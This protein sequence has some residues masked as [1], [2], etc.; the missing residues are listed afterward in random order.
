MRLRARRLQKHAGISNLSIWVLRILFVAVIIAFVWAQNNLVISH[1]IVF[2]DKSIPKSLVGFNLVQVSDISN[3]ALDVADKVKGLNPDAI[4]VTGGYSDADGNY[5][6]SVNTINKLADMAPV[7]YIYSCDDHEDY[8]ANSKGTNITDQ[9]VE[10]HPQQLDVTAF[11]K[12]NYG[13]NIIKKSEK[14]DEDAIKYMEYVSN[15][16]AE[17]SDSKISIYGLDKYDSDNGVYEAEQKN[18]ELLLSDEADYKIALIGNVNLVDKLSQSTVNMLMFGGTY[19]TNRISEKYKS[20]MYAENGTQIVVSSGVGRNGKQFRFMNFPSV[21]CITFSDGT[22][23]QEN[24]LEKFI[25]KFVKDVGTIYDND[26]GFQL[27]TIEYNEG[28]RK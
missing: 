4:V 22:I 7:Y 24:P 13:D 27:D 6:N 8:L 19:G 3:S 1:K 18:Y 12:K 26:G 20:G 21:Q 2:A 23:Q 9:V 10:L 14:N 25:S 11:I 17:T 16:L 28:E 5:Q 15:A